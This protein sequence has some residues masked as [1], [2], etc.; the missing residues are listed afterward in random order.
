MQM[1]G[2]LSNYAN[3]DKA[4]LVISYGPPARPRVEGLLR[5][6]ASLVVANI[7]SLHALT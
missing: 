6:L 2:N 1:R 7:T 5:H 3:T 4:L